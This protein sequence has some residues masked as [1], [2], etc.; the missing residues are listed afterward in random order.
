[1]RRFWKKYRRKG[2]TEMTPWTPDYNMQRVSVSQAD[3][4]GGSPKSGDMIARNPD[5]EGDYWLV[6]GKYFLAKFIE[7]GDEYQPREDEEDGGGR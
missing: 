2:F 1:V 6:A 7:A 4:E 5:G 3:K